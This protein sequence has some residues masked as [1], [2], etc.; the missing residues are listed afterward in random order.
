MVYFLRG[1]PSSPTNNDLIILLVP[2][3]NGSRTDAQSLTN[4]RRDG[5]LSLGSEL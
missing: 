4:F 3:Q 1:I 2:L 5:N